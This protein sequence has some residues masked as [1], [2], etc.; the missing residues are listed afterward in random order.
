MNLNNLERKRQA[1]NKQ[2]LIISDRFFFSL[3][4]SN[5]PTKL[6]NSS[7]LKKTL[8]VGRRGVG[9]WRL[10]K[11][12]LQGCAAGFLKFRL[13]SSLPNYIILFRSSFKI[14]LL[15][16][17]CSSQE[18][19]EI[20]QK[21]S[22]SDTFWLHLSLFHPFGIKKPNTIIRFSGFLVEKNTRET[23]PPARLTLGTPPPTSHPYLQALTCK[24]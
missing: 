1:I 4:P 12:S 18:L 20:T 8:W 9:G 5:L 16:L 2:I 10:L 19:V 21:F 23:R 11:D 6:R 17:T 14:I 7:C 22:S 15:P 13:T 3:N 24:P